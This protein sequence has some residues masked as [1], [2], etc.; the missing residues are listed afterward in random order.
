MASCPNVCNVKALKTLGGQLI[1]E[2][3]KE[4]AI[5]VFGGKAGAKSVLASF[6]KSIEAIASQKGGNG[7]KGK[8]KRRAPL[9]EGGP[10]KRQRKMT[11][12]NG[13]CHALTMS[14]LF[15]I[16]LGIPMVLWPMIESVLVANHLLPMLCGQ[17]AASH[18]MY[19]AL[20]ATGLVQSCGA[21]FAV[22]ETRVMALG[23]VALA[24]GVAIGK[25]W[26]LY[27]TIYAL[28]MEQL[29]GEDTDDTELEYNIKK[30]LRKGPR[31]D[32][33]GDG[34]PAARGEAV[35]GGKRRTRKRKNK[36][37]KKRKQTKGH[38]KRK[39]TKGHKKRKQTKGH[40]KR[41]SRRTRK[42]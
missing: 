18:L 6:M 4:E 38:K 7:E 32:E 8:G 11:L 31:D 29:L 34:P 27:H 41:K 25:P 28:I 40:K 26:E 37:H 15:G 12:K 17:N 39:Q 13:I 36:G 2:M 9:E 16:Y 21:V 1:G 33:S 3:G 24:G 30:D 5:R 20:S 42:H 22:Y 23:A 19:Q 10:P 35:K 14:V